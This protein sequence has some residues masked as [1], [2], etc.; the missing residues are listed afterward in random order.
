MDYC[1]Q[2][3]QEN[4]DCIMKW[5]WVYVLLGRKEK[6]PIEKNNPHQKKTI[7]RFRNGGIDLLLKYTKFQ[8]RTLGM[9]L[10]E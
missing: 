6:S 7:K 3:I 2:N 5:F 4:V 9:K 8:K 1:R 10:L